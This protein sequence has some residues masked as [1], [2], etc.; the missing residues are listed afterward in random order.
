MPDTNDHVTGC[1]KRCQLTSLK[2]IYC[3]L[4]PNSLY[5]S[6]AITVYFKY[7]IALE[8]IEIILSVGSHYIEVF[9]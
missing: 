9:L 4:S 1:L 7:V 3:K 6:I 5:Q 8:K 2:C